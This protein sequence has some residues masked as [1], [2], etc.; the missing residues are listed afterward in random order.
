MGIDA[1]SPIFQ[2]LPEHSFA[3]GKQQRDAAGS[4][5]RPP[6]PARQVKPGIAAPE[7][8]ASGQVPRVDS[9]V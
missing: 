3:G 1:V 5:Q 7:D 6:H 9:L 8:A 2:S 4:D